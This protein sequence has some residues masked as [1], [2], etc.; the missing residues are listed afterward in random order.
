MV[1]TVAAWCRQLLHGA[2]SCCVVVTVLH[3]AAA[4][5]VTVAAWCRQLLRGGNSAVCGAAV[6]VTVA[7][8]DR[9]GCAVGGLVV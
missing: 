6:L 9:G 3:G 1:P 4:V 8:G 2:D 5:L 7:G